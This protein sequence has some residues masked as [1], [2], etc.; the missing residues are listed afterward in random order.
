MTILIPDPD[1]KP[2]PFSEFYL[3]ILIWNLNCRI[4]VL[5]DK[6]ADITSPQADGQQWVSDTAVDLLAYSYQLM[7][8]NKQT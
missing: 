1:C 2:S 5:K 6:V 8:Q 4:E 3:H 7:L